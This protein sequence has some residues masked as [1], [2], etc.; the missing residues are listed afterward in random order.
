MGQRAALFVFVDRYAF[1]EYKSG[2]SARKAASR[3]DKM[4][5][6]DREILVDM[7]C[8]RELKGIYNSN[9]YYAATISIIQ[10]KVFKNEML[11]YIHLA[12]LFFFLLSV[13]CY[14]DMVVSSQLSLLT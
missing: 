10:C 3:A 2:S 8:E 9:L 7:E 11:M 4:R 6:D 14:F 13:S 12:G 1:I 5:V